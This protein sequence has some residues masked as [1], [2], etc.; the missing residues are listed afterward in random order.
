ML[1]SVAVARPRDVPAFGPPLPPGATFPHGPSLEDFLLAKIIN[2]QNAARKAAGS[3][4]GAAHQRHLA[5]RQLVVTWQSATPLDGPA[6]RFSFI[7][8]GGKKKERSKPLGH[9]HLH[10][11]GGVAW[12]A[13]AGGMACLL[14]V[15]RELVVLVGEETG[16]VLF[17]CYCR[18]VIGW[19]VARGGWKLYFQRGDRMMF[20]L[21]DDGL[22][23]SQRLQVTSCSHPLHF[24]FSPRLLGGG[25]RRGEGMGG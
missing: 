23:L 19:S 14:A 22:E 20:S 9:A 16:E 18:D 15:S 25:E 7:S 12:A 21:Q 8:L 17:S 5:L 10:S 4:P 1:F 13:A 24:C 2:G 6:P 11:A 3:A